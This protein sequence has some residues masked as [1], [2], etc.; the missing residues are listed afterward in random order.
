MN[1]EWVHISNPVEF[2]AAC[3]KVEKLFDEMKWIKNYERKNVSQTGCFSMVFGE[4]FRPYH[5]LSVA[6]NNQKFQTV[7][8]AL[9]KLGS[10]FETSKCGRSY[11]SITTNKNL[12]CLPHLDKNNVGSSI[13]L[14][15]GKFQG[16]EV[17][18]QL[19]NLEQGAQEKKG[20]QMLYNVYYQPLRFD[21]SKLL[22]WTQPFQGT[23]YS[24]VFFLTKRSYKIQEQV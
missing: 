7:Y 8:E 20:K 13:I 11:R 19:A 3:Q 10:H 9:Q 12:E 2:L 16:G 23:R 21:G 24:I 6:A 22:H 18:V 15:L 5:G 17:G 14:S 1:P 4:I